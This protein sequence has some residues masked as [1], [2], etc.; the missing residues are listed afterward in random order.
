M[1]YVIALSNEKGGV[2]K[3]TTS[4]SL[5]SA[6]ADKNHRVLLVDLDAQADLTLGVGL[7]PKS[8]PYATIDILSP[9]VAKT[10]NVVSLCLRTELENLDII[11][12]NGDM[13]YLE[14]KLPALSKSS[15][16]LRQSLRP[17]SPLPYDFIIID[18]PPALGPLTVNALAAAD[19][20]IIPTQAEYFSA[21]SL[22][23]M[24]ALIRHIRKDANPTLAYRILVT[25]LDNRN[26]VHVNVSN[27]LQRVFGEALFETRIEVD[28]KIRES[29]TEGIPI[30]KYLP[31]TRSAVQYTNLAQELLA[32]VEKAGQ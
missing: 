8:V 6:L 17:P 22:S 3:T 20:L 23:K 12:S 19:L 28:T 16:F 13:F 1:T 27:Y 21:H 18:C 4:L 11:P 5:G 26:R 2:A 15:L 31:S 7:V 9:G 32:Y 29:Q 25:L 30:I 24:M 10:F 14:Q